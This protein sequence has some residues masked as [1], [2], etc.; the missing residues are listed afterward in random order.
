MGS[1]IKVNEYKDFNNNDIM[2]SDGS[3]NVT[4][5]ADGLKNVPAFF[6]TLSADDSSTYTDQATTKLR[7]NSEIFDTAGAYDNSTNYRF[8]VPSGQAGKYQINAA[9]YGNKSNDLF[10]LQINLYLN[11]STSNYTSIGN[12]SDENDYSA[13]CSLNPILN[14]SAG[15]YL[16]C[17]VYNDVGS[18]TITIAGTKTYFGAYKLIGV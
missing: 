15:D 1:I 10:N 17:Y 13:W 7:F 2:T 8:T 6:A 12:D 11:G 14:L 18:G 4:V 5:N 3:G 16:E 9:V